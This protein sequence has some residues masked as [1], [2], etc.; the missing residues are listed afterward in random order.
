MGE[1]M[2]EKETKKLCERQREEETETERLKESERT[3]EVQNKKKT[4]RAKEI[5]KGGRMDVDIAEEGR[6]NNSF[7][8]FH[9]NS[10]SVIS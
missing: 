8:V 7:V 1:R 10:I 2:T 4:E 6:E 3:T 9:G 5:G